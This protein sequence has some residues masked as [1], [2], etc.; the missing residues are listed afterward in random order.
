[1]CFCPSLEIKTLFFQQSWD[2]ARFLSRKDRL[3]HGSKLLAQASSLTNRSPKEVA[4]FGINPKLIFK[5]KLRKN[6]NLEENNLPSLGLNLLAKEPK[7]NQSIV[8]FSSDSTGVS[9]SASS[10]SLARSSNSLRKVTL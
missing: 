3:T 8:V 1:L 2:F 4:P 7:A 5:I 9:F 10:K 6:D